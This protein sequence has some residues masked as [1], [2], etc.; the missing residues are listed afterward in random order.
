MVKITL[1]DAHCVIGQEGD[2]CMALAHPSHVFEQRFKSGIIAIKI[3]YQ[4][5]STCGRHSMHPRSPAGEAYRLVRRDSHPCDV[6]RLISS[7]P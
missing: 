1:I 3:R 2:Q 4:S 6:P 7:S 5:L